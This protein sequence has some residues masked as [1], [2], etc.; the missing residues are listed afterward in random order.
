MS[1]IMLRTLTVGIE[2]RLSEELAKLYINVM[3]F[4]SKQASILRLE[5]KWLMRFTGHWY[6]LS[7]TEKYHKFISNYDVN[8][9]ESNDR[10]ER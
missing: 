1:T 6:C 8:T 5:F 9:N 3:G 10:I 7:R 2:Y 4:V